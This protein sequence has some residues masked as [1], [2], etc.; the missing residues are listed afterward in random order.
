MITASLQA[1]RIVRHLRG[2]DRFAASPGVFA[3]KP[4]IN[5]ARKRLGDVKNDTISAWP[6]KNWC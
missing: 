5:L 3:H 6:S 1:L 4:P 2:E